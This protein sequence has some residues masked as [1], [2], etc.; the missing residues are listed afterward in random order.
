VANRKTKEV[1]A[2]VHDDLTYEEKKNQWNALN[3]FLTHWFIAENGTFNAVVKTFQELDQFEDLLA[4]DLRKLVQ[5]RLKL[6]P[7]AAKTWH[8]APFRGL[9]V[10]DYEHAPIFFGRTRESS[11][12]AKTRL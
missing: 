4:R 5:E 2:S 7:L 11:A 3:G 8:H 12:A 6:T 9:E 1:L 10:F